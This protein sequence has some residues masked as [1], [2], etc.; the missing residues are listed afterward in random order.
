[1]ITLAQQVADQLYNSPDLKKLGIDDVEAFYIPENKPVPSKNIEIYVSEVR[2]SPAEH[3]SNQYTRKD[4]VIQLNIFYGL[5]WD[6]STDEVE[7]SIS[8][9]LFEKNWSELPSSGHYPDLETGQITK[10]MQFQ[11][12]Q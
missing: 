2:F 8:S 1:M 12:R 5:D 4:Q 7:N 3:G 6:G 9:F 10:I 11:R